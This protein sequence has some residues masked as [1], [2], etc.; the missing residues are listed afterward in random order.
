[1]DS[2]RESLAQQVRTLQVIVIGLSISPIVFAIIVLIVEVSPLEGDSARVLSTI[3]LVLGL[4]GLALHRPLG[5]FMEWQ[6]IKAISDRLD[7]PVALGGAYMSSLI[8]SLAMT[9][10]AAFLNL[11]GYM[12]TRS[13]YCLAMAALLVLVN[14][15]KFPTLDSVVQ[16]AKDQNQRLT[17]EQAFD[18]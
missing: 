2:L 6:S 1:M 13:P 17:E 18:R 14:L 16:W 4:L 11:L 12:F 7:D 3:C 10:G 15:M 9:E 8:V 5:R